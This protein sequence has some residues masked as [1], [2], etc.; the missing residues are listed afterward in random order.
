MSWWERAAESEHAPS[1]FSLGMLYL[2]GDLKTVKKN[3]NEAIRWHM[4]SAENG[5]QEAQEMMRQLYK[6]RKA[7]VLKLFPKITQRERFKPKKSAK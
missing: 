4:R 5:Y 3:V 6:T 7:A 2:T 1:Q